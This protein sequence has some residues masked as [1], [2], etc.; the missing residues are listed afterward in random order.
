M[1]GEDL[2]M[3]CLQEL[4][5][6]C[7][8]QTLPVNAKGEPTRLPAVVFKQVGGGGVYS[9]DKGPAGYEPLWELRCWATTYAD[10]KRLARNVTEAIDELGMQVTG[11]MDDREGQTGTPNVVLTASGFFSSEEA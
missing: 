9:H 6:A 2:L 4:D 1:S 10:A 7:F 11:E 8:P 5:A 3:A